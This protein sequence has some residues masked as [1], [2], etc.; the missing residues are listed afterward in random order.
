MKNVIGIFIE[1]VEKN[2]FSNYQKVVN[3]GFPYSLGFC[4]IRKATKIFKESDI[5]F[6]KSISDMPRLNRYDIDWKPEKN[7][8]TGPNIILKALPRLSFYDRTSGKLISK[9]K[10][11][12]DMRGFAK[13]N[14]PSQAHLIAMTFDP[15]EPGTTLYYNKSCNQYGAQIQRY[16]SSKLKNVK[17]NIIEIF[18]DFHVFQI[19]SEHSLNILKM[20]SV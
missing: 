8:K 4:S 6:S 15:E 10:V 11:P 7:D 19:F 17:M 3:L 12:R 18:S 13:L 20:K 9:Q 14:K 5:V 1:I 2:R 16:F